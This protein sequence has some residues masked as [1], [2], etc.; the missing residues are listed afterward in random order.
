MSL[1]AKGVYLPSNVQ[2]IPQN[3][4]KSMSQDPLSP[5]PP[6]AARPTPVAANCKAKNKAT[7]RSGR[8]DPLYQAIKDNLK[9]GHTS[10]RVTNWLKIAEFYYAKPTGN[11]KTGKQAGLAGQSKANANQ[12]YKLLKQLENEVS[13]KNTT[14]GAQDL[15]AYQQTKAPKTDTDLSDEL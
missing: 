4:T 12:A 2:F 5:T 11:G 1:P 6:P 15:D 7:T 8:I 10:T 9:I 14:K 13:G 3:Y